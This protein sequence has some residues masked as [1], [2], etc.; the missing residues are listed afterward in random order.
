MCSDAE[1]KSDKCSVICTAVIKR[2]IITLDNEARNSVNRNDF[3]SVNFILKSFNRL[4]K[5]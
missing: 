4:L 5:I 1:A 2:S 3:Y